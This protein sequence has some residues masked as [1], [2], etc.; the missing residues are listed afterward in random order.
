[1]IDFNS[2]AWLVLRIIYAWMFLYP[3]LGLIRNWDITV[4]TTGLLFK[5]LPFFFAMGSVIIMIL[6]SVSILL[7]F[8]GQI[9]AAGLLFF[10]IGGALIHYK[11]AKIAENTVVSKDISAVDKAVVEQLQK[12]A[13]VGHVTSA[14]KNFPLAAIA[15]FFLIIGT[16][17]LSIT[18][19]IF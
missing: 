9:G 16:G 2:I 17:P 18:A 7:G 15:F 14:E 5:R 4:Q 13:I 8:F 3:A 12:L 11:L 10:N 6:G 1:M 19:N